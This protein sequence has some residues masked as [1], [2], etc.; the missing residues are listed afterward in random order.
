L[1]LCKGRKLQGIINMDFQVVAQPLVRH[2]SSF[3]RDE[4]IVAVQELFHRLQESL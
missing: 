3:I 4:N 1:G 2:F